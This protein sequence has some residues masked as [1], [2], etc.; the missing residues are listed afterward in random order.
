MHRRGPA[1]PPVAARADHVPMSTPAPSPATVPALPDALRL[2]AVDL[3]VTSLDRAVAWY[4]DVAGVRQ[5]HRE[6]PVAVLGT[7][8]GTELL[9][10]H[11]D[12]GARPAGRHAGLFHVALLYPSMLELSRTARRLAAA[13]LP[14]VGASDHG[15]SEALYLR[16]PDGNGVELY[17]DRPQEAWPAPARD[18]E[19]VGM[20]TAA[21]DV[22]ALLAHSDADTAIHRH[23]A[24]GLLVGHVHVH[25][26]DVGA[27]V[28]FYRDVLGFELM[29][30]YPG[31]AFLAAGGYHH[32]LAVNT[33]A[34]E[35]VGPA[36]ERTVGLRAWTVVLPTATDVAAVRERAAA[37]GAPVEEHDAGVVVRDPWGIAL[38]LTAGG[39]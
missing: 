36:P 23:A 28:A 25:V 37:A 22:P 19:R 26:G 13:R 15:V 35:G 33:W 7:A 8:D 24:D 32:H 1:I 30:T 18:G 10:L 16:D 11:E 29:T 6:D 2:G 27:A 9:R 12:A 20:F 5:L 31:A 34:G 17:A 4:Q 39:S 21:L 3:T 14:I 38:R